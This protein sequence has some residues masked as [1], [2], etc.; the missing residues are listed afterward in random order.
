MPRIRSRRRRQ[1]GHSRVA[2]SCLCVGW[3]DTLCSPNA[4]NRSSRGNGSCGPNIRPKR[5]LDQTLDRCTPPQE[6]RRDMVQRWVTCS[7]RRNGIQKDVH[8]RPSRC[9]S[10]QIPWDQQNVSISKSQI[11]VAKHE[12]GRN[13]LRKGMCRVS[14]EQNQHTTY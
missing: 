6:G 7:N 3:N 1:Q 10:V 9:T 5:G 2:G 13:K 8:T 14:E 4:K 11:L 12:A